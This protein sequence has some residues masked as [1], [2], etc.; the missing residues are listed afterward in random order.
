MYEYQIPVRILPRVT[1]EI[2]MK[3]ATVFFAKY[4]AT[5]DGTSLHRLTMY[6]SLN[7]FSEAAG[8]WFHEQ[9]SSLNIWRLMLVPAYGLKGE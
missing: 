4:L 7:T 9:T 3:S 5:T 2:M 1:L 6:N 8:S